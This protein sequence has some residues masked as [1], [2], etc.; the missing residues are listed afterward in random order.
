RRL[1]ERLG[2]EAHHPGDE[3]GGKRAK[4]GVVVA[5]RL[6]VALALDGDAVFRA[7]ELALQREEVLIGFEI[8]IALDGDQQATERAGELTL[9]RRELLHR[10]RIVQRL[11]CELDAARA[12]ARLRDLREHRALLRREALDGLD[13][14]RDEV[15]AA[16]V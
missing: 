10:L 11:R 8:R 13:E 1:E 12:G 14:I 3:A 9:R 5:D 7:L 6:V 15:G 2:P 16:L 4:P